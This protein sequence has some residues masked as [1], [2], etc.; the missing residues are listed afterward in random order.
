MFGERGDGACIRTLLMKPS[1]S[2]FSTCREGTTRRYRRQDSHINTTHGGSG[3]G[4]EIWANRSCDPDCNHILVTD[5]K[6]FVMGVAWVKRPGREGQGWWL[7]SSCSTG[8]HAR[9]HAGTAPR[10]TSCHPGRRAAPSVLTKRGQGKEG[11]EVRAGRA[12]TRGGI[13]K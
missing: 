8:R 4:R 6:H 7:R 10:R 1:R 5:P 2:P 11:M 12:K 9:S 3:R 13:E